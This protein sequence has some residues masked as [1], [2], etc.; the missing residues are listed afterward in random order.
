MIPLTDIIQTLH[1]LFYLDSWCSTAV[2]RFM[3]GFKFASFRTNLISFSPT[4]W[5]CPAKLQLVYGGCSFYAE[6]ML[7]AFALAICILLN[8]ILSRLNYFN[9]RVWM[10]WGHAYI[11]WW[12]CLPSIAV[13]AFSYL[14]N[15][16]GSE[17]VL[18]CLICSLF[19]IL[20]LTLG[21][22]II[23]NVYNKSYAEKAFFW[24]LRRKSGELANLHALLL[25]VR[26]ICLITGLGI[27]SSSPLG[28]LFILTLLNVYIISNMLINKPLRKMPF[29]QIIS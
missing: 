20:S 7:P 4:F 13:S 16:S 6:L 18:A 8:I 19:G 12:L 25:V 3:L 2:S 24:N 28:C 14:P 26:R 22:Q 5:D 21:F 27:A 15:A 17:F 10:S 11:F 23:K 29:L 1:F 9:K